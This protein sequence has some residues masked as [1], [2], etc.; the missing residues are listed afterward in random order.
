MEWNHL[1]NFGRGHYGLNSCEIILNLAQWLRRRCRL[2]K[3]AYGQWTDDGQRTIKI[4][5]LEASAPVR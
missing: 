2:N 5:K 3:K 4:A 1:C